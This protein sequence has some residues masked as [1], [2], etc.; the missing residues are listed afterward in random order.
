MILTYVYLSFTITRKMQWKLLF[1]KNIYTNDARRTSLFT[2]EVHLTG[3]PYELAVWP[4]RLTAHIV[5]GEISHWKYAMVRSPI[6][7][8]VSLNAIIGANLSDKWTVTVSDADNG[9]LVTEQIRARLKLAMP[10]WR[11]SAALQNAV[12]FLVFLSAAL[13]MLISSAALEWALQKHC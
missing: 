9:R 11:C 13:H 3:W 4:W 10:L 8:T 12:L 5:R 1:T 7:P 6:H 2:K